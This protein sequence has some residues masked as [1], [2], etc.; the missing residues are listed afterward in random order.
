VD[1]DQTGF[2]KGRSILLKNFVYFNVE[3]C[4]LGANDDSD[5]VRVGS[6]DDSAEVRVRFMKSNR[7]EC[8][9]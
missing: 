5:E 4:N 2:I 1:L 9:F 3:T 8:I 6:N 7:K